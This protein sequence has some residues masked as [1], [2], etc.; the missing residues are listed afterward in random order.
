[1]ISN[2]DAVFNL[3]KT[4]DLLPVIIDRRCALLGSAVLCFCCDL[5][6]TAKKTGSLQFENRTPRTWF[7]HRTN[8]AHRSGGKLRWGNK[9]RCFLPDSELVPAKSASR[10]S[11]LLSRLA[12]HA[13]LGR[14]HLVLL[15]YLFR[16]KWLFGGVSLETVWA[17]LL[18]GETNRRETESKQTHRAKL[19]HKTNLA[20]TLFA[21]AS[22]EVC[23]ESVG[24]REITPRVMRLLSSISK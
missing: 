22:F 15:D 19:L 18:L 23:Y 8:R 3:L 14:R 11:G 21:S 6:I 24:W 13:T 7:R 12:G 5:E 20:G 17:N 10:Q 16:L 1:M 9:L 2:P 4:R